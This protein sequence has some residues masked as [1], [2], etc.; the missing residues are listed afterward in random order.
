MT[1]TERRARRAAALLA[2]GVATL[3]PCLAEAQTPRHSAEDIAQARALFF[4]AK[5]QR[6]AGDVAGALEK[7]KAAHALGGTPLTA[8]ELGRTY[9]MLGLLI[10]AREAFLAVGRL[11]LAKEETSRSADARREAAELAEQLEA[12]IPTVTIVVREAPGAEL[13]VTID[14]ATVPAAALVAPRPLNPGPHTLVVTSGSRRDAARIVLGEAEMKTVELRPS[15]APAPPGDPLPS[16][17]ATPKARLR[18]HQ[19]LA[20]ASLGVGGA[21]ALTGAILGALAIHAESTVAGACQGTV[22]PTRVDGDLRAGRELGTGSTVAFVFG[23]AAVAAG[24]SG[25]LIA[26][27]RPAAGVRPWI[28]PGSAGLEGRF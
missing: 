14:G 28:G 13:V 24:V 16:I 9:R 19:V 15:A 17:P 5:E 8:L 3:T 11:P 10:E 20:Y 18:A 1:S 26:R 6:A 25:L 2:L 23:G 21:G 22:C 7:F 4:K 27:S 12:R